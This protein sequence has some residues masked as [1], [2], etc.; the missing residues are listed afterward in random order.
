[1]QLRSV[2]TCAE[3]YANRTLPGRGPRGT[4]LRDV[5]DHDPVWDVGLEVL[6][7]QALCSGLPG[8]CERCLVKEAD[9]R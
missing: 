2:S 8:S 9:A 1:M 5:A 3:V 4:G 6:V 7:S